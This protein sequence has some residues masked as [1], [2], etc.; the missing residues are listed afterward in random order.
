MQNVWKFFVRMGWVMGSIV[1]CFWVVL[2][3][4]PGVRFAVIP[5]T[6]APEAF[7]DYWSM[8][9]LCGMFIFSAFLVC[10]KNAVTILF[11]IITC[12]TCIVYYSWN[13]ESIIMVGLSW[14][15]TAPMIA[16]GA[17]PA[18]LVQKLL[19]LFG[20]VFSAAFWICTVLGLII[21]VLYCRLALRS[22]PWDTDWF[23]NSTV[24]SKIKGN[25]I[26]RKYSGKSY[27]Y[28]P[29]YEAR[30]QAKFV[31]DEKIYALEQERRDLSQLSS[32]L[33]NKRMYK[34]ANHVS[35]IESQVMREIDDLYLKDY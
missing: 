34:E 28:D 29:E 1:L 31:R 33:A 24:V 17:L 23:A 35:N 7:E 30:E 18:F 27:P 25:L 5:G 3:E 32:E 4:E 15:L 13:P 21:G 14:I 9:A 19:P 10:R 11:P 2:I 8:S 26:M 12:V 22:Y 20:S 16:F 6:L